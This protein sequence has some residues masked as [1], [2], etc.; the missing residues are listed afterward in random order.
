MD[1]KNNN[2]N[3][4]NNNMMAKTAPATPLDGIIKRKF[5]EC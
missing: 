3:N 4:S 1:A 2:S 5:I